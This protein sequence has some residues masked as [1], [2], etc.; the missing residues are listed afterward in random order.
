MAAEEADVDVEGDAVGLAPRGENYLDSS[1]RADGGPT[2]WALDGTISE[3]NRVAIE[4]MLLEEQYYLSSNKSVPGRR[5]P[6][7]REGGG[8]PARSAMKKPGKPGAASPV[9]PAGGTAK[10]T[11]EERDLFEHGLATFGRRWTKIA[12]LI[13]G[14]TVFQVKGYARQY[15]KNKAKLEGPG[16]EAAAPAAVGA[17]EGP[18]RGLPALRGR[19]DPNLNAVRIEQLS[20]DEDVDITDEADEGGG[21]A[22]PP[23]QNPPREPPLPD[24]PGGPSPGPAQGNSP[25][26]PGSPPSAGDP[27]PAEPRPQEEG[28]RAGSGPAGAPGP[29]VPERETVGGEAARPPPDVGA[30]MDRS[31]IRDEEKRAIPE[32]FEG[33][34]AK[35]P[36]RYLKIRNYI[37]DQWERSKPRYLNKTSV[38]PGLKSCG[39]VNCIGRI[40]AYLESVGAINRGCDQAG[41]PRAQPG[42]AARPRLGRDPEGSPRLA[43]RL[44]SMRARRR[45]VRDPGGTWCDAR[46]LEGQTFEHL[47]AEEWAR[48]REDGQEEDEEEEQAAGRA[49]TPK[50]SR[51]TKSAFDPF[52]L[53][54]CSSFTAEKPEPFQVKV[55]C[56]ALLVM[57]LHAHTSMAEVIGLL[58]GRFSEADRLLEICTAE[59]CSSLSTG[60]QCE[61]DPV[62]QTQASEALA[63][64][65][66]S[67]IGWYH[68]H[69]A[70]DPN[71]SLRDIDTQAKY[72][73]Y[74]S[75]GGAMFV[76]VIVSP[77]NRNNPLPYSQVTCLVISDETSPDGSYR[78]PYQFA[79]Q[80]MPEE[81]RWE[82]LFQKTRWII[83]KYR[84][85]RSGVPMGKIF[86][87]ASDLTCLQKLLASL[88][89]TLGELPRR[90]LAEEFLSRVQSLF[91]AASWAEPVA[92]PARGSRPGS[93]PPARSGQ[94]TR[95][96]R[97]GR[98]G[99]GKG[100]GASRPRVTRR[101]AASTGNGRPRAT[102]DARWRGRSVRSPAWETWE[103]AWGSRPDVRRP[104]RMPGDSG[105]P[106][107]RTGRG[108]ARHLP[109]PPSFPGDWK[110]ALQ[111][112]KLGASGA[113]PSDD[114]SVTSVLS[115]VLGQH[116]SRHDHCPP[117]PGSA[118]LHFRPAFSRPRR[119]S[120]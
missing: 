96:P 111:P 8:K 7:R 30:A 5:W 116:H 98:P 47:S 81:P 15:F 69:P 101:P 70:F 60:L 42:S 19:A 35:T 85:S 1:W 72:Q 71:P 112:L 105:D 109:G 14:R 26:P 89:K 93:T 67:V 91:L 52:Q 20:G 55:A 4:K 95:G 38:R 6:A 103:A 64:R 63:A 62:S 78:L 86:H 114:H 46:D 56:E 83:E 31:V 68:S 49:R 12:K 100:A 34:H 29:P 106:S 9:R 76:G 18:A 48:R 44:Q 66:Y 2:P 108:R 39:D 36:E 84:L 97:A 43:Q 50:G 119:E 51:A 40:H 53:I 10:W 33:R 94:S 73:S 37:L 17:K 80:Q 59:P 88:R 45:R 87:R 90:F 65:G 99:A 32:F 16:R 120:R 11:A 58:G 25:P 117:A 57:D 13:S 23:P 75:R 41:N 92:P 110:P 115:T 27:G 3:E 118:P 113:V 77:Y 79:M 28:L 24:P 54:P 22:G 107:S 104:P 82:L 61:M 21:E 74:F 102:P